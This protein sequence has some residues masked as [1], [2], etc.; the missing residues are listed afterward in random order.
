MSKLTDGIEACQENTDKR[1]FEE[2]GKIQE[3]AYGIKL[4]INPS[5]S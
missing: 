5:D 2:V 3:S 1:I 4:Q